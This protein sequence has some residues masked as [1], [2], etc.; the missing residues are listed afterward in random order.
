MRFFCSCPISTYNNLGDFQTNSLTFWVSS[1]LYN[2]GI[3]VY[4][5][6]VWARSKMLGFS[7][8]L[9]NPQNCFHLLIMCALLMCFFPLTVVAQQ[10]PKYFAERRC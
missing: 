5:L 6:S 8:V 7:V 9:L 4:D 1:H 2:Q 10:E 3:E